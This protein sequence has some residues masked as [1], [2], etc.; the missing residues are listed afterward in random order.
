[1]V[2]R[3]LI[4]FEISDECV[5]VYEVPTILVLKDTEYELLSV[6]EFVPPALGEMGHYKAHCRRE[7][8]CQCYDDLNTRII[9][10]TNK[11]VIPHCIVYVRK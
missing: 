8:V 1:M 11:K 7:N 2:L 3:N 5:S 9:R 10:S 4:S 6:M